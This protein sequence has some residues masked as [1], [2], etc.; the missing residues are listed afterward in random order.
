MK[1][2]TKSSDKQTYGEEIANAISHGLMVPLGIFILVL[3]DIEICKI[4]VNNKMI[5]SIFSISIIILYLTSTLYHSLSFT[6]AH[7]F[8]QKCDHISIYLLIWGTFSPI[9]LLLPG[10]RGS[11]FDSETFKW[12]TEG[13]FFFVCQCILVTLG[14]TCKVMWFDKGKYLHLLFYVLLGWS[15]ILLF[16]ELIKLNNRETLFFII[17]GGC[18]Y[19]GGV[20]FYVKDNKKYFHFIWHLFVMLG[21]CFHAVGIYYLLQNLKVS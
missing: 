13:R 12:F 5:I 18:C 14:I 2:P 6:K 7:K 9:L 20:Y 19:T 8:F 16:P 11:L 10:L 1:W 17:L 15:G 21:T 3:F 4:D